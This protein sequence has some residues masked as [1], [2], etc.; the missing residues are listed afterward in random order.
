MPPKYFSSSL[1]PQML[2]IFDA[3]LDCNENILYASESRERRTQTE[4]GKGHAKV[5]AFRH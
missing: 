2:T 4:N 3:I 5:C 1:L